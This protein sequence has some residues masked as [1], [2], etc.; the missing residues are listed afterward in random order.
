VNG[1]EQEPYCGDCGTPAS[2]G[3]S[4]DPASTVRFD[5]ITMRM[6]SARDSK[7]MRD[8]LRSKIPPGTMEHWDRLIREMSA[9]VESGEMK[10]YF[11]GESG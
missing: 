1:D 2:C 3:C 4:C 7:R 6:E 5:L 9:R 10:R 11:E 8:D